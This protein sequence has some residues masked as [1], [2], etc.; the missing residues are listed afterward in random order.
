[1]LFPGFCTVS[2]KSA[3]L[4]V[5]AIFISNTKLVTRFWP[6]KRSFTQNIR[7]RDK[8]PEKANFSL[9]SLKVTLLTCFPRF[10]TVWLESAVFRVDAI[11]I[12]NPKLVIRFWP[13]KRSFTQN[14]RFHEKTPEKAIFSLKSLKVT[15]L[16]V[17][18]DFALFG[19]KAHFSEWTL[20]SSQIPS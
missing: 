14:I 16:T 19:S 13:Q 6:Q 10:R 8:T 20:F 17:S 1:M 4:R 5:E 3:L 9:K 11:F 12:S 15:L 2:L 18:A 7:F